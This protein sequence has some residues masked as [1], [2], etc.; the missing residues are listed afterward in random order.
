M[1]TEEDDTM[2]QAKIHTEETYNGTLYTVS[3]IDENGIQVTT[4][5]TSKMSEAN[6]IKENWV[7]GKHQ[8]LTETAV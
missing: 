8:V 6:M 4:R 1:L 5:T 7:A 3:L 2:K